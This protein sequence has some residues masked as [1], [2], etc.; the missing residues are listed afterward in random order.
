MKL[1]DYVAIKRGEKVTPGLITG[2]GLKL[3]ER[4][5][6]QGGKE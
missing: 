2:S 6:V 4:P 5:V 1:D 3:R